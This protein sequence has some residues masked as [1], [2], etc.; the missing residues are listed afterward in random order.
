[1]QPET[2][3][4]LEAVRTHGRLADVYLQF[5]NSE[6]ALRVYLQMEQ[7]LRDGSLADSE[8][9]AVK[10]WASQR[11]GCEYCLS[12]HSVKAEKVGLDLARQQSIRTGRPL[13]IPRIDMLLRLAQCLTS[14]PGAIPE[15]LLREARDAG[16]SDEN[17]VD[18]TMA[19]STIYFTN[20]TNHINDSH[21]TLPPAPELDE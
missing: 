7:A 14:T 18:L 16:L 1:L 2:L 6:P 5:A 3:E 20:L 12:V 13:G 10:L 11:S 9:E 19:M 17:L 4:A 21:S 15:A 8:L